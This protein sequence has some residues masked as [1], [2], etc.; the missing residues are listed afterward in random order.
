MLLQFVYFKL[1]N[2]FRWK[3]WWLIMQS[4]YSQLLH[5]SEA[6]Q[7]VRDIIIL[8]FES[9]IK[10]CMVFDGAAPFGY[11]LVSIGTLVLFAIATIAC[12]QVLYLWLWVISCHLRISIW[13]KSLKVR[14][15]NKLWTKSLSVDIDH[16]VFDVVI[17]HHIYL[18]YQLIF[19]KMSFFSI[20]KI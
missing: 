6:V 15:V 8:L 1:L 12:V 2:L 3:R 4:Q 13:S 17:M 7:L 16:S 18:C 10:L 14:H 9:L 5:F 19:E 20:G 11:F